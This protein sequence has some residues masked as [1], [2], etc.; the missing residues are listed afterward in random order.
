MASTLPSPYTYRMSEKPDPFV[1]PNEDADCRRCGVCSQ[2]ADREYACRKVG[3]EEGNTHLPDAAYRLQAVG[4]V[5]SESGGPRELWQCPEC[6]TCYLYRWEY[7]FLIGCGG[8]EDTQELTRLTAA[9]TAA[10][11]KRA[12]PR[13]EVRAPAN[14]Q[15][16]RPGRQPEM[17]VKG[18][19]VIGKESVSVDASEPEFIGV[20]YVQLDDG[21]DM[22]GRLLL[23][24]QSVPLII[25][26]LH[27][28]LN[29]YAFTGVECRCGDDAFSVYGS[30]SDQQPIIN[31][32]N[33]RPDGVPHG[34]L[35]G[36][37]MT[38]AAAEALFG[39]L[40]AIG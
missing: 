15:P 23:E 4:D 10:W 13:R 24:R 29:V 28:S 32:L 26:L 39:Q 14:P 40:R 25:A 6:T 17:P 1:P 27:A 31:I 30:G 35:T 34:G 11:L 19:P 12:G 2:L 33:R 36:L 37:M 20:H 21:I 18:A 38:T 5:M 16:P 8:S 22:G 3:Q 7:E 9:E